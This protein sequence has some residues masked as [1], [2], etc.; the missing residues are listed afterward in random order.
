MPYSASEQHSLID[1]GLQRWLW[2]CGR[3]GVGEEVNF[4]DEGLCWGGLIVFTGLM[5]QDFTLRMG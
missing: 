1:L 3:S 2:F 5:K 4:E